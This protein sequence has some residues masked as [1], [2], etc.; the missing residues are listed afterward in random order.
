VAAFAAQVG[1]E[2]VAGGGFDAVEVQS[3][4]RFG[5]SECCDVDG[6]LGI[7]ASESE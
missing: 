7:G 3:R 5:S 1:V 6:E 4:V 2:V